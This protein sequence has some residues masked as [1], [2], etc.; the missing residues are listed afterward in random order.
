MK[1]KQYIFSHELPVV[2]ACPP[3]K[4]NDNV[5]MMARSASCFGLT[6]FILTG[7]NKIDPH[8]ARDY[9]IEVSHHNSLL[10]VLKKH[11][12][13]GYQLIGLEQSSNS[14]PSFNYEFSEKPIVFV[15]GNETKGMD[16]ETQELMDVM[17]EIPLFAE[18]YSLN[19]A[20][21]ATV[22]FYEYAKQFGMEKTW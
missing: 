10:P 17:L 8:I 20:V 2:I 16:I 1:S 19:V 14:R 22:V 12:S 13:E 3:M 7:Q 4:N 6:K 21:A 15:V 18:P 11:K 5:S 9:K